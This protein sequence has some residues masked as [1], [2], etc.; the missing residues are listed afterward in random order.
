MYEL[1]VALLVLVSFSCLTINVLAFCWFR[2]LTTAK[3]LCRVITKH[4]PYLDILFWNLYLY[5][6]L[7]IWTCI[8][9]W[10]QLSEDFQ[11]ADT[12]YTSTNNQSWNPSISGKY[13]KIHMY[14][15]I[16][17]YIIHWLVIACD[18][19]ILAQ[20]CYNRCQRSVAY[21]LIKMEPYW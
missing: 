19:R 16:I 3:V 12:Y 21:I 10:N 17:F 6:S 5:R 13:I 15:E 14:L 9:E 7:Y 8:L 2:L 4:S 1:N 20:S 11:S 18:V